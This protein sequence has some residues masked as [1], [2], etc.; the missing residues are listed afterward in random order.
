MTILVKQETIALEYIIHTGM[1]WVSS[2]LKPLL[3]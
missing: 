1:Q 2:L 3:K